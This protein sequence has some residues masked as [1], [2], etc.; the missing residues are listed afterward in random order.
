MIIIRLNRGALDPNEPCGALFFDRE[1][2]LRP[3][4]FTLTLDERKYEN[5][6]ICNITECNW[7]TAPIWRWLYD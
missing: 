5:D 4:L 6:T 2:G 3:F 7:L 1:Q